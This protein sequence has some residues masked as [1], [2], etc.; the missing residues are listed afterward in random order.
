MYF[1]DNPKCFLFRAV[2]TKKIKIG[3]LDFSGCLLPRNSKRIIIINVIHKSIPINAKETATTALIMLE[4]SYGIADVEL[5]LVV[6]LLLFM[7]FCVV[8]D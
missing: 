6:A 1:L 7:L 8:L 3:D 5:L 2:T 4:L